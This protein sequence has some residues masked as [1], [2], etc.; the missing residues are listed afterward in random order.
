LLFLSSLNAIFS[1]YNISTAKFTLKFFCTSHRQDYFLSPYTNL[2]TPTA[3]KIYSNKILSHHLESVGSNRWEECLWSFC[4]SCVLVRWCYSKSM[5]TSLVWTVT[6]YGAPNSVFPNIF[7]DTI[8]TTG[9]IFLQTWH[10]L[11]GNASNNR[12][13]QCS[14]PQLDAPCTQ[15][16]KSHCLDNPC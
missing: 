14:S 12:V 16:S 10:L 1:N 13:L 9:N 11:R 5:S 2:C 3:F 4:N 7:T 8:K 6:F 15:F